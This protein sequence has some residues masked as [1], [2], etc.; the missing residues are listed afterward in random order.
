[1]G[2]TPGEKDIAAK[3]SDDPGV[4]SSLVAKPSEMSTDRFTIEVEAKVDAAESFQAQ[5]EAAFEE[6]GVTPFVKGGPGFPE[7]IAGLP[8][9][10]RV[11]LSSTLARLHATRKV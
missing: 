5:A 1:M 8:I 2:A 10:E 7:W 9:L 6:Y 4:G 11:A 3:A